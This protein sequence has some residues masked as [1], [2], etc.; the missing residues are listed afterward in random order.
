MIPL[1]G[2]Q[3][4]DHTAELDRI[5][6]LPRRTWTDKDLEDL[7]DRMTA[8]LKTPGGTQRLRPMQALALHDLYVYGGLAALM[9]VGSGK[10]LVSLLAA[11]MVSATRPLLL[12]PAGLIGKTNREMQVLRKHWRIPT[13]IR[14]LSY[15]MLGREQS[16][17][18]LFDPD[19][20][21]QGW[22]PDLI[23]ADEVHKLK[24][25][26][27][28]RTKRVSRYMREFPDTVFVAMSGTFMKHS[29]KDFAHILRWC[30]KD[31]APVPRTD[32]EVSE[33]ADSIDVKVPALARRG[34]G[35]LLEL[36]TPHERASMPPLQAARVGFQRR[37][38]ETPGVV[39]TAGE[40]V[41]CSL[42][43]SALPYD[44]APC[45]EKYY[46]DLRNLM[47]TP[48]GYAL[49]MATEV[50]AQARQMALGFHYV[51]VDEE[52]WRSCRKRLPKSK[53]HSIGNTLADG[54]P[55]IQ[56]EPESLP[57]KRDLPTQTSTEND[58]VSTR[59]VLQDKPPHSREGSSH[60][61]TSRKSSTTDS[62][63]IQEGSALSVL[64]S[65][66]SSTSITATIQDASVGSY[67]APATE[68]SVFSEKT[69]ATSKELLNTC[70]E[71]SRLPLP[72]KVSRKIWAKFVRDELAS[73]DHLDTELQVRNACKRGELPDLE[74]RNWE[75]IEPTCQVASVAVWQDNAALEVAAKWMA[76]APGLVWCEHVEFA[77]E[78]S[79]RTGAEYYRQDGCNKAGQFVEEA[80]C[81]KSIIISYNSC[82]EG[83]NLQGDAARGWQGYSRNLIVS[84]PS[85]A[86][87]IEQLLGRTHRDGQLADEVTVDVLIGCREHA[88][89]WN[90]AIAGALAARDTLGQTQKILLADVDGFPTEAEILKM[91]GS[92]WNKKA[93]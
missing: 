6:R 32:G 77:E 71:A 34:A 11:Y 87:D 53:E 92:R 9:R 13:N 78:L 61:T 36:C 90:G 2:R 82:K 45:M 62:V 55:S 57:R 15:E 35:A 12:L 33:W 40:G 7:A 17:T 67:A 49:T 81:T 63:S 30:L 50:W 23:I 66:L 83:R 20:P 54:G 69:L 73:S 76:E 3:S 26:K 10:T 91:P 24:T 88:M 44:M 5:I 72:W 19:D 59:Q 43:I 27:V 28:G 93:A 52:A 47:E 74:Y 46:D 18:V 14:M 79:R 4:V 56:N 1:F 21:H 65:Q 75:A 60:D 51:Q 39:T 22:K 86:D 42:Y 80:D 38:T 89:A 25:R 68:A 64:L 41:S 48:D 85:G 29:I 58:R 31:N 8:L 16:A 84:M 70:L 37:L